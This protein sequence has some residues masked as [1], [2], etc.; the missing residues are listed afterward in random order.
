M[1][2]LYGADV[3]SKVFVILLSFHEMIRACANEIDRY[4]EFVE[5]IIL[6]LMRQDDL[7]YRILAT[8]TVREN[9]LLD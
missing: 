1:W 5:K 9:D 3:C 6:L 8:D 4:E 7:D 2:L